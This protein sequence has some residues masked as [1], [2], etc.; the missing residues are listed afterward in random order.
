MA[1]VLI[2]GP[3]NTKIDIFFSKLHKV[4]QESVFL[5]IKG[6]AN[7]KTGRETQVYVVFEFK[8]NLPDLTKPDCDRSKGH[9]C[10]DFWPGSAMLSRDETFPKAVDF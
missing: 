9:R 8:G 7:K 1:V 10:I 5:L 6:A 4:C 2:R 3:P